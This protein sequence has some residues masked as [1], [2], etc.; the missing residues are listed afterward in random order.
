MDSAASGLVKAGSVTQSY[1]SY[2][3]PKNEQSRDYSE[4]PRVTGMPAFYRK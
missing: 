2:Q 4:N 3:N 1:E